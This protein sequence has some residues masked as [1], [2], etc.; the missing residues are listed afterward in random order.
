M[1]DHRKKIEPPPGLA[2]AIV[3]EVKRREIRALRIRI[4][5]SSALFTGSAYFIVTGF[6]N[7]SSALTHSGFLDFIALP[8]SDFSATAANFPDFTMTI[9]ESFPVF[10]AA[11]LLGAIAAGIWSIGS[12]VDETSL[13][14]KS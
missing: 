1:T 11:V 8:F 10:S 6:I 9:A 7:F 3:R 4:V 12:L 14:R 5:V 2:E 13:L